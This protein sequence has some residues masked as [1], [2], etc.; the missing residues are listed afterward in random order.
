MLPVTCDSDSALWSASLSWSKR[1]KA[2]SNHADNDAV[3]TGD[4]LDQRREDRHDAS[5]QAP[6]LI[7]QSR[8]ADRH[9]LSGLPLYGS[10]DVTK[11]NNQRQESTRRPLSSP[12]ALVM[13]GRHMVPLALLVAATRTNTNLS[14]FGL[15]AQSRPL[16][17]NPT[18]PGMELLRLS[19][20]VRVAAS[21]SIL[22]G[23]WSQR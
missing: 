23:T 4:G 9:G 22:K 14:K 11:Q 1:R 6:S 13:T 16:S 20:F 2:T 18:S 17:T 7:F 21:S 8:C 19:K 12:T 5:T 15:R 3:T 10:E